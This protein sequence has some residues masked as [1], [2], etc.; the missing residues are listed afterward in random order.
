VLKKSLASAVRGVFRGESGVY[1]PINEH[2]EPGNNEVMCRQRVFQH[3]A[4][5]E[6]RLGFPVGM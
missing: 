4:N 6:S 1:M 5:P 3:A 2:F